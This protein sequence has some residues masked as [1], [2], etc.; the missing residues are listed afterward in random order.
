MNAAVALSSVTKT[1]GVG[2][3]SVRALDDISLGLQEAGFTAVMGPSGS[4]KSTLLRCAAGLEV[5][6]GGRVAIDGQEI[7]SWSETRLTKFRRQHVGFVFQDYSLMPYL[8]AEENVALPLRLARRRVD[9]S[10]VRAALAAVDMSERADRYPAQ[11]SGG[12][13]QRVA[14]ARAV[15]ARPAVVFADEPTGALDTTSAATVLAMLRRACD[16]LGQTIVMVTHDP[17]AAAWADEVLYLVDG[18]IAGRMVRPTADA[19]AGQMAHLD[20][21]VMTGAAR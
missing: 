6:D 7:G 15:V 17:N 9:R 16:E 5:V 10:A 12:Q 2:D 13:Q 4:G 11:L 18:R 1:F 19:I 8:T 21:L 14:L 20:D 3:A